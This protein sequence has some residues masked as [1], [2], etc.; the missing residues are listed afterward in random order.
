MF[1]EEKRFKRFIL[2][3]FMCY[4]HDATGLQIHNLNISLG[5]VRCPNDLDKELESVYSYILI[6]LHTH[7][8]I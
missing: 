8:L 3:V 5:N 6:L 2:F 4:K 7:V 1:P